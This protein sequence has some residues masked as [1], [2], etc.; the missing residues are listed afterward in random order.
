[1]HPRTILKFHINFNDTTYLSLLEMLHFLE[2]NLYQSALVHNFDLIGCYLPRAFN[3]MSV[4]IGLLLIFF[5]NSDVR[6]VSKEFL[7]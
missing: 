7:N 5:I 4:K 3:L 1:M 6:I 2:C